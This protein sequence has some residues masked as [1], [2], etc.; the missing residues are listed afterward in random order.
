MKPSDESH[1]KSQRKNQILVDRLYQMANNYRQEFTEAQIEAYLTTLQRLPED[2][3]DQA[4]SK[5]MM[6]SPN[7]MPTAPAILAAHNAVNVK[8]ESMDADVEFNRALAHC[9]RYGAEMFGGEPPLQLSAAGAFALRSVGWRSGVMG[10]KD[11]DTHWLKK[12]F[13]AAY[14]K[15]KEAERDGHALSQGETLKLL[16]MVKAE[17]PQL[18]AGKQSDRGSL[19]GTSEI[20]STLKA[21]AEE[22]DRKFHERPQ[23][24]DEDRRERE[25]LLKSQ[26]VVAGRVAG[27]E[28]RK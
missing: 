4:F 12:N 15:F 8:V 27:I 10:T 9:E 14:E 3:I 1:R 11:E 19:V 2:S 23:M 22:G 26:L 7:F 18:P 6:D 17:L 25:E 24:S 20:V 13:I 21:V 28:G 16:E 5:A